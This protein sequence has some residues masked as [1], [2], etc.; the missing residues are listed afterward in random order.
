MEEDFPPV[1]TLR[2]LDDQALEQLMSG[3]D[4]SSGLEE[5]RSDLASQLHLH[6][7]LFILSQAESHLGSWRDFLEEVSDLS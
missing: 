2:C 1:L 6:L 7:N 3:V 5:P 4:Q